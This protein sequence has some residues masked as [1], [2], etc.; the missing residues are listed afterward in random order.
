MAGVSTRFVHGPFTQFVAISL[1]R[2][3]GEGR[4]RLGLQWVVLPAGQQH[5]YEIH[6]AAQSDLVIAVLSAARLAELDWLRDF[7]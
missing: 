2:S 1:P 3:Q 7:L 6:T 4:G 5:S